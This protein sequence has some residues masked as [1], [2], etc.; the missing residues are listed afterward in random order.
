M[1]SVLKRVD[2]IRDDCLDILEM[3]KEHHEAL[4][5]VFQDSLV[6]ATQTCTTKVQ[7]FHELRSHV[8]KMVNNLHGC[9]K[10]TPPKTN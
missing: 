6:L 8:N 1:V 5:E 4:L 9:T 7:A 10:E 3:F 2:C